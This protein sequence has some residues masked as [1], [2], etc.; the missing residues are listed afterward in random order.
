M[1]TR[2]TKLF[3][4]KY[5]ILL[6]G[7]SWISVPKLVA[8]VSNAGGL[9]IL[10]TGVMTADETRQ[11][12][13]EIRKLTKKPFAA[14]V[15]LYFPGAERN[16]QVLL[17]E[18][19]PVINYALGKGDKLT[20]AVH[21]YG[22]KVIATVTTH[23]HSLA[24]ERS[25]AD[26]LIVTGHEAAGHGG[27]VTSL[28]LIPSIVDA[29]K[30]PVIAAGGFADGR[31]LA[32]ALALGAEGI[33]MGTRLMNTKESPVHESMKK[34]SVEKQIYDTI[35]TP[36]VD[37]LPARFMKSEIA[38]KM[39][40]RPLNLI[41]A[42]FN[43]REIAKSLGFPWFKLAFAILLSG[44]GKARQMATM[45]NGFKA[46]KAGTIEGDNVSGVLPLG[47]VTGLI[48]DTPS[49]KQVIERI[50]DEARAVKKKVGP[51][52]G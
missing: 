18:K 1:K 10:A 34:L 28:V 36:K 5:P 45:A 27:A 6:S 41:T 15:T 43:S 3:G 30:I 47:Q 24:A 44:Y 9:G 33:S 11:A 19:V 17:E 40:K 25:G 13:R 20:K 50:V 48:T 29:V 31:G 7:M 4:I 8:A 23:K 39:A 12:V 32:A 42:A 37:G 38:V 2:I 52:I 26:A 14:N 46:F 16:L 22:G 49:V 51:M 35:Y 21:A